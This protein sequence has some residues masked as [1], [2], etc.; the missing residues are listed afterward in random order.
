MLLAAAAPHHHSSKF[1]HL[2]VSFGIFGVFLVSIVDSSF[3]PLPVPGITD[4]MLVVFAAQKSNWISADSARHRRLRARR[5]PQLSGRPRRRHA[6]SRKARPPAHLQARLRLDGEARHPL[7]RSACN[8]SAAHAALALRSRRGR[9]QDVEEEVPHH[10]HDQPRRTPRIRSLA[11]H[12]LRQA[13]PPSLEPLLRASGP[14]PSSSSSGRHPHRLRHRLLEALQ[15]LQNGR[16]PLSPAS[17]T[18]PTR[19]PESAA[20]RLTSPSAAASRPP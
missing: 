1:F 3:V 14:R 10:L 13:R 12:L 4:I 9:A 2:L 6:V 16:R 11:R 7:R 19:P 5:I 8:P 15:D 17:P 20:A 18:S